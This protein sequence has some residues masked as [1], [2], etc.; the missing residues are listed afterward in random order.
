HRRRKH[1]QAERPLAFAAV[2]RAQNRHTIRYITIIILLFAASL[3]GGVEPRLSAF[4]NLPLSFERNVGQTDPAVRFVAH[5]R[6][7]AFSF[8]P[9][10]VI[11]GE[12]R[13]KIMGGNPAPEVTGVDLL[14]G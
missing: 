7:G 8:T 9:S 12:I 2:T 11:F 5:A 1:H 4:G 6:T 3:F 13:M 14:P 10:E